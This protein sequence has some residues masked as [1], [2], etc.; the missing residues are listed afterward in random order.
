MMRQFLTLV[1]H[2]TKDVSGLQDL[3]ATL[4]D[5]RDGTGRNA[6]PLAIAAGLKAA[7][8]ETQED[9]K[10][11]PASVLTQ[12]TTLLT[13][14][15]P[16]KTQRK[17]DLAPLQPHLPTNFVA[18]TSNPFAGTALYSGNRVFVEH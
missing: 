7:R 15:N 17:N 13:L 11:E 5:M 8:I 4:K 16:A 6:T 18:N 14:H 2:V 3:Q 1:I 9:E 10:V 12:Q